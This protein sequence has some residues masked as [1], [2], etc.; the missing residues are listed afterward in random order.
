MEDS[1]RFN[2]SV[3]RGAWAEVEP[4]GNPAAV[5]L[6]LAVSNAAW[7]VPR[8]YDLRDSKYPEHKEP[9][10][11]PTY[12]TWAELQTS[13]S[14]CALCALIVHEAQ[15]TSRRPYPKPSQPG[16]LFQASSS[17]RLEV[18]CA[19]AGKYA[20]LNV[21]LDGDDIHRIPAHAKGLFDSRI[22]SSHAG[23]GR[24]VA[25]IRHW[26]SV[27]TSSHT[28]CPNWASS[29]RIGRRHLPTRVLDVGRVGDESIRLHLSLDSDTSDYIALSYCWGPRK[30][31]IMTTR[32]S[33]SRHINT[34]INVSDLPETLRDAVHLTR[35]LNVKYL[36][37]D[38][39]CIV[40]QDRDDWIREAAQMSS[41]YSQ[42][43]LTIAADGA[44]DTYAGL[45][46]ERS[47][48][49]GTSVEL[50]WPLEEPDDGAGP[51]KL[52]ITPHFRSF[53]DEMGSTPLSKRG[54]TFQER[55]LSARIVHFTPEM[56]YWEC[57]D[58]CIGEDEEIGKYNVQDGFFHLKDLLLPPDRERALTKVRMH[59]KWAWV[60]EKY[61]H[62]QLTN[63]GD[64]FAALEGVAVVF[65]EKD[66]LGKYCCGLWEDDFLR[67]L[68]WFSSRP[69]DGSQGLPHRRPD[70]YRAPT[71]SW[72]SIHGP[73]ENPAIQIYFEFSSA[74][75]EMTQQLG[76]DGLLS[77]VVLDVEAVSV[78]V[79]GSSGFGPVRSAS[80]KAKGVL[81]PIL[82][83]RQVKRRE[84]ELVIDGGDVVGSAIW[85]VDDEPPVNLKLWI[86][87]VMQRQKVAAGWAE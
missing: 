75:S 1:S 46:R 82:L 78:E 34:G 65:A 50:P 44:A 85:D 32:D 54:W 52:H 72:A 17:S 60:V 27:C 77:H 23:D 83:G 10:H 62:R 13:A 26:L 79:E 9:Y 20:Q 67:H 49:H 56:C 16:V 68:L 53:K 71:W 7:L 18:W 73:V 35:L 24:N 41:V 33:L 14:T 47:E 39:L 84:Y 64:L 66:I 31:P 2:R 43:L 57:K 40:Q 48:R 70:Q 87:P 81:C 86:C 11:Y 8:F 29:R 4:V 51:I 12:S 3:Q 59:D 30:N 37:I 28:N 58:A 42:A 22:V 61:T 6:L 74:G 80:L 63:A 25:I 15:S 76:K 21:A 55:A 38:A 5:M 45:F 19:E 36:W 69:E